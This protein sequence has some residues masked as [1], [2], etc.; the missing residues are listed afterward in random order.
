MGDNPLPDVPVKISYRFS[1]GR[2]LP[3]AVT[4]TFWGAHTREGPRQYNIAEDHLI[5]S[6]NVVGF[7]C[8]F[9]VECAT[10]LLTGTITVA[11]TLTVPVRLGSESAGARVTLAA[12]QLQLHFELRVA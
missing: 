8:E 7:Y 9:Y 2:V 10:D 5:I 11:K 6:G 12:D 3:N 1:N 4:V